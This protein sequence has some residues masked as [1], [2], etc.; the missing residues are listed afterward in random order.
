MSRRPPSLGE[1]EQGVG[2]GWCW[3]PAPM[4]CVWQ[5]WPLP[6][7]PGML[8]PFFFFFF[9]PSGTFFLLFISLLSARGLRQGGPGLRLAPCSIS[10][11][12]CWRLSSRLGS[13]PSNLEAFTIS[14]NASQG[15]ALKFNG[16]LSVSSS[17]FNSAALTPAEFAR[18]A[19]ATSDFPLTLMRSP[20]SHVHDLCCGSPWPF[21]APR[22]STGYPLPTHKSKFIALA[23]TWLVLAGGPIW[24]TGWL[25]P[26]LLPAH[27]GFLKVCAM[28][29]YGCLLASP[30]KQCQSQHQTSNA[31]HPV[32]S[33]QT[34]LHG[35]LVSKGSSRWAGEKTPERYP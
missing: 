19:L 5:R 32:G 11:A 6:P 25:L 7:S 18:S 34:G 24:V 30:P 23:P 9:F 10:K 12:H 14:L 31:A 2:K 1:G 15:R 17:S 28:S 21:A 20:T 8:S 35:C 4:A 13:I 22:P 16:E 29:P 3:A 26:N 33:L 27:M